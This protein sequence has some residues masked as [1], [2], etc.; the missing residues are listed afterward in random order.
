[1]KWADYCISKISY[2]D[3]GKT[4]TDVFVHV[5][6]GETIEAGETKDRNWLVQKANAGKSFCSITRTIEGKWKE[7]GYFKFETNLFKSEFKLPRNI[8][9]RKT[10]VSYFH[11]DDQAYKEQFE[12]LFGDLIVSKSVDD[13]DINSDNSDEYIK[14]L[15]QKDFLKDTTVLVVLV[16]SKTKCRKHVDWEIA[17][18]LSSRVGGTSGLIGLLLPTHP[19]YGA[20]GYTSINVPNRLVKNQESDFANIYDWAE[21][22]IQLQNWL[23][24]AFA[25]K[26]NTDDIVNKGIPQMQKNTC[27]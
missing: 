15:I 5:D 7:F 9:K 27:E 8:T 6:N 1:M 12:N 21:D 19:D 25:K 16:G 20:K 24:N 3:T 23:E 2:S 14:Q 13:G 17:G 4:I 22:R 26:D 10:F 11:K 18:A